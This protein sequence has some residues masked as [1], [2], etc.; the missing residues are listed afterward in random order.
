MTSNRLLINT[1]RNAVALDRLWMQLSSGK[2]IQNPSD[3]PIVASRALRFRTN[4][5]EVEQFM[6]NTNQAISWM[7][8]SEEHLNNQSDILTRT[9]SE[10]LVQ[11]ASS[12]YTFQ[13]RQTIT[14]VIELM[15]DQMHTEMNGTFAGR[16]IF[17]GFR[18]DQ[19]PILTNNNLTTTVPPNTVNYEIHK[20]IHMRDFQ[21]I[22]SLYWRD[23]S[24]ELHV[25]ASPNWLNRPDRNDA[26][27]ETGLNV[28][29]TNIHVMRL[30]FNH[31]DGQRGMSTPNFAF[32][33][34]FTP[35][36]ERAYTTDATNPYDVPA[37]TVRFIADTGEIVINSADAH[38]F[39]GGGVNI[40]YGIDGTFRGELNPR[41]FFHTIDHTTTPPTTFS[42][43]NQE[44][45]FE[46]G[47][48]VH[49]TINTEA[50]N[51]YPWQLF[52][53]MKAFIDWVNGVHITDDPNMTAEEI[54]HE[55]AF[56][57]EMLYSKFT[58]LMGRMDGH[59]QQTTT[60][61]TALGARMER[62]DMISDR[63]MENRDTFRALRDQNENVDYLEV[64]M[65]LNATE[66]VF[67]AALQ[68]GARISQLSLANFI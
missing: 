31:V 30:P 52:A 50:R 47:T 60:E 8:V 68:A 38:H 17:S 44:I 12:T 16:Y 21:E 54:A 15:F 24:G 3:N 33:A 67:Q 6:R 27:W 45:Q 58:N 26:N 5:S 40:S 66:A 37:G 34:G 20:N 28:T 64:M 61:F 32:P 22:G 9:R 55:N 14:R 51:A 63:L 65:R 25:I 59:M 35:T 48:N 18:T 1:N 42:Q 57:S 10:L 41:I 7:E 39:A 11:G 53:D 49:L 29:E 23:P 2:I 19:P 62:M 36:V 46:L 43:D 56:F 13:N 4:V